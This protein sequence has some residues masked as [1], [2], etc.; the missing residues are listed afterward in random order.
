MSNYDVGYA[1]PPTHSRFKKGICPNPNGRPKKAR[2]D[3]AAI[4]RRF[5][6]ERVA[7]TERGEH[8]TMS[9]QELA[10]KRLVAEALQGN[11]ESAAILLDLREYRANASAADHVIIRILGG[12][13]DSEL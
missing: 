6:E 11:I 5:L 10:I 4:H 13:S 2:L 12:L 3:R 9:R 7:Y 8:R 1:K